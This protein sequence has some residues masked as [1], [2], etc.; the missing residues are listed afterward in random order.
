MLDG[1]PPRVSVVR[2]GLK[3]NA[4]DGQ[5][6]H[7][8]HTAYRPTVPQAS[9]RCDLD[10]SH[11][12]IHSAEVA[13]DSDAALEVVSASIP[14]HLVVEVKKPVGKRG[15]SQFVVR[16]LE[17]EL[18]RENQRSFIG[19]ATDAVGAVDAKAVARAERLLRV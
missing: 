13:K 1:S 19:E 9:G 4:H 11:N 16:S 3:P 5:V 12:V 15:Y 17:R 18:Q 8:I 10:S 2:A 7:A 6:L 14:R